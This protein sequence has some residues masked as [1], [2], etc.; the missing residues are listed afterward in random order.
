M[1]PAWPRR[2][3]R[4]R[5][6]SAQTLVREFHH[7]RR[8]IHF[9]Q[10]GFCL[11]QSPNSHVKNKC[12]SVFPCGTCFCPPILPLPSHTSC[13]RKYTSTW[14]LE[15]TQLPTC[16]WCRS[17]GAKSSHLSLCGK[18]VWSSRVRVFRGS[19]PSQIILRVAELSRR[20]TMRR[21]CWRT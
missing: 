3:R 17:F 18:C 4:V 20:Y 12:D 7:S 1:H 2:M 21:T 19:Q 11:I 6:V 8:P 5:W 10:A 15:Q 13:A 16:A 9:S 14:E